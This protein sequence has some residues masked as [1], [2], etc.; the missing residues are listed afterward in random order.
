MLLNS[1]SSFLCRQRAGRVEPV[2]ALLFILSLFLCLFYVFWQNLVIIAA[3]SAR[4]AVPRGF[5]RPFAPDTMLFDAAQRNA[6]SAW[7]VL[8]C[9]RS[10]N[11]PK[12]YPDAGDPLYRH[13]I[14]ANCSRVTGAFGSAPSEMLFDTAQL[15]AFSYHT[16]PPAVTSTPPNRASIVQIIALLVV[17]FGPNCVAE[18]PPIN[19]R[20]H[21]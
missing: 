20:F 16:L 13:S 21:K 5:K 2:P 9:P 14:D 8:I 6:D 10:L 12:S 18:T 15:R 4:V 11:C 17:A 1:P 19:E 3:T 7:Y